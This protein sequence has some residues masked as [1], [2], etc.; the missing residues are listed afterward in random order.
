MKKNTLAQ[1]LCSLFKMSQ[2]SAY[3]RDSLRMRKMKRTIDEFLRTHSPNVVESVSPQ[4]R[5]M[6]QEWLNKHVLTD[7]NTWCYTG[8]NDN[9]PQSQSL[10]TPSLHF[11]KSWPQ[12]CRNYRVEVEESWFSTCNAVHA[13]FHI[14]LNEEFNMGHICHR[15][16]LQE[17]PLTGPH[18][19]IMSVS[20]R[21]KVSF[22][23]DH[24]TKHAFFRERVFRDSNRSS[25]EWFRRYQKWESDVAIFVKMLNIIT[26]PCMGGSLRKMAAPMDK[27]LLLHPMLNELDELDM[28]NALSF[29]VELLVLLVA[30]DFMR[31]KEFTLESQMQGALNPELKEL[32]DIVMT[33]VPLS[34]VDKLLIASILPTRDILGKLLPHNVRML[35]NMVSYYA[36]EFAYFMD[37]QYTIGAK[38]A[39]GRGG[40]VHARSYAM[41]NGC[42]VNS[43][44]WN[45][46]AGTL[47]NL[48]RVY[49]LIAEM[50]P[51]AFDF[52]LPIRIPRLVAN[53]QFQWASTE[54][55]ED[56]SMKDFTKLF[57]EE[58]EVDLF[59]SLLYRCSAQEHL[60]RLKH[61]LDEAN[62]PEARWIP[63]CQR[64][65]QDS[66]PKRQ[67]VRT[68]SHTFAQPDLVCGIAVH[69]MAVN[70]LK[71][72]GCFG[73][74][75]YTGS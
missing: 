55:R 14:L 73:A 22:S 39:L 50:H 19:D 35:A 9:W 41:K 4:V 34:Q 27:V 13:L 26:G 21:G 12:L 8:M 45:G 64:S 52:I 38:H 47:S 33:H 54:G 74:T 24:K 2:T 63:R 61:Q 6:M 25:P 72:Q 70:A 36:R 28:T 5:P 57:D 51:H 68:Q 42:K 67:G 32:Y 43:T 30:T 17:S 3:V 53:D 23:G 16:Q 69:P 11:P 37:A 10:G 48:A 15:L 60:E 49:T 56:D 31:R 62:V 75:P 7:A 65:T 58:S 40:S 71:A 18:A 20:E 46:I 44:A 29:E 66:D 59:A 1:S